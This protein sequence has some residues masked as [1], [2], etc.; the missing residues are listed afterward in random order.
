MENTPSN[1]EEFKAGDGKLIAQVV[2][3]TETGVKSGYDRLGHL[4]ARYNP[5]TDITYDHRGRAVSR[6]NSIIAVVFDG[7]G[8][9]SAN[10]SPPG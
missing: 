5:G 6:G 8:W 7:V 3:D 4:H 2:T 9:T 10:S 1:V